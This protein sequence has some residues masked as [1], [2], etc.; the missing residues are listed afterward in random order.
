MSSIDCD[1]EKVFNTLCK[2]ISQ[3]FISL[4]NTDTYYPI[5]YIFEDIYEYAI[6]KGKFVYTNNLEHLLLDLYRIITLNT[7]NYELIQQLLILN[8][9]Y[10]SLSLK[11]YEDEKFIDSYNSFSETM[12]LNLHG[13][14]KRASEVFVAVHFSLLKDIEDI[15]KD[16][17][18]IYDFY[19]TK[20]LNYIR[21]ALR[22][23]NENLIRLLGYLQHEVFISNLYLKNNEIEEK[24]LFCLLNTIQFYPD[25]SILY[26]PNY[27][28]QLNSDKKNTELCKQ[29]RRYFSAIFNRLSNIKNNQV[30]YNYLECL[31]ECILLYESSDRLCQ[32]ELLDLYEEIL[33]KIFVI[34]SIRCLI[35]F[36]QIL[37][38]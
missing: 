4:N 35:L 24:R 25:Y 22:V 26:F 21:T 13:F 7:D 14:N 8:G 38:I 20:I 11:K 3:T 19:V 30:V 33:I 34:T 17:S 12:N 29:I 10:L 15:K 36:Y 37:I 1:T 16:K 9:R 6:E 32:E 27:E 23:K 28:K 31:N 18:T 5:L 2:K